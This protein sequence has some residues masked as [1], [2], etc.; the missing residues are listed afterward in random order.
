[1][2]EN[3]GLMITV[4]QIQN[5]LKNSQKMQKISASSIK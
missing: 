1:M 5:Y 4:E 3:V 2:Q